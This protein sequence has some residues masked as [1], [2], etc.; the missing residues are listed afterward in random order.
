VIVPEAAACKSSNAWAS[1]A[2]GSDDGPS[3]IIAPHDGEAPAY[4]LEGRRDSWVS[5]ARIVS[6]SCRCR[7]TTAWPTRTGGLR[8]AETA[9][10]IP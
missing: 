4:D 8:S 2:W 7:T 6:V 3:C 9:A 1:S 5:A 10:A